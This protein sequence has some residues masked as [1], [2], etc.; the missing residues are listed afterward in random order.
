[1]GFVTLLSYTAAFYMTME[2]KFNTFP[3][4]FLWIAFIISFIRDRLKTRYFNEL[5]HRQDNI[6]KMISVSLTRHQEQINELIE[7]KKHTP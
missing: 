4:I 1:M 7:Q 3:T 6:D 2:G 5:I